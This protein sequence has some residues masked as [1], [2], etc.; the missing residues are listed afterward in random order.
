[1][2]TKP[3]DEHALERRVYVI[4]E[5]I[6]TE[7]EYVSDLT[8]L[9]HEFLPYLSKEESLKNTTIAAEIFQNIDEILPI[10]EKFLADLQAMIESAKRK[11]KETLI[12]E[13]LLR[14]S[15][16]LKPYLTYCPYHIY[17]MATLELE[18][19]RNRDFCGALMTLEKL[20]VCRKLP[21]A[22]FLGRPLTRMPRYVL[23][24]K[25]IIETFSDKSTREA[26][27]LQ[28]ALNSITA[29]LTKIDSETGLVTNSFY[30]N[31]LQSKLIL[32]P[33]QSEIADVS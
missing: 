29:T 11:S 21:L 17:A 8:V 15:G 14:F 25:N 7:T 4:E 27:L 18:I 24:I 23:L 32:K 13:L 30:L 20:P 19:K 26:R 9:V 6:Q 31:E 28:D 22:S 1:M 16:N 2:A 3:E 5:L 10:H 33:S 12:G